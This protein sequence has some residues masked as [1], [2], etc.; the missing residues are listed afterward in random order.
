MIVAP[1]S[2]PRTSIPLSNFTSV[3]FTLAHSRN[4]LPPAMAFF[5]ARNP[6]AFTP[7]PVTIITTVVYLALLIP[8]L[9]IHVNVPSAPRTSPK[10][11][12]L[13]EAWQDLQTLTGGFHPYNS[14]RNDEVRG[15]LL[16]RIEAIKREV[17][18]TELALEDESRPDVFVFDDMISNL[19]SFDK[20]TGVYFEGTNILVYIRGWEDKKENWWE[21][22]GKSPAGKGGVLVNAHYDSV[23]TGYGATDDGVG[24]V[25][26]LQLLRY[27]L[28]PGHAPRRGLV[29]LFN[30]GEE[31]YLNGARAY[32]QHPMAKFAH[33][34][35]NLEGAGAGGRATLFR[36][37]DTEVTEAYS[38]TKYPFGTVI[39]A[40]G[41]ELVGS[42]TDY[43]VFEGMMGLRGLDVAFF[44][45]RARYHTDQDDSR[46]TSMDSVW[47]MLSAAVT[48]TQELVSDST[49]RFDGRIRDDG[50]VP[51]GTGTKAVWFDLFGSA[52]AVFQVH[53]LFALSVTLLIVAPLILLVTS[54]ALS[55]ADKMYLFRSTTY[56]EISDEKIALRGLRG[57]FR[58]PFMVVIPTA[59]VVGLAYLVTKI[60]PFIVHSSPYAVWSMMV[61]AWIFWL[62]YTWTWLFVLA[63][64]LLV[65]ATTFENEQGLGGGYF[66]L[67]YFAGTFLATW[68]SYLELFSLPTKSEYAGQFAQGSRRPS[69]YGS[70]LGATSGDEEEEQEVEEE[71]TESTSLLHGRQ[72]TTFA[73]YVNVPGDYTATHEINEGEE[74]DPHLYGNEQ[75]WSASMPSW[76]WL[77]Q[78]L[79]TVPIIVTILAPIGLLMTSA[80]GQTGQDGDPVLILYLFVAG[81]T[82]LLFMPMLPY[83]HRYTYHVPIFL[84]FILLGTLIYNLVAFPF[85]DSSRVKMYFSQQID[86]EKGNSTAYLTGVPPFVSDIVRGLPSSGG[87]TNCYQYLKRTQCSWPGPE[88]HVVESNTT[89]D[90]VT[91]SISEPESKSHPTRFE[92]SGQN[93]RSCRITMDN[94]PITT[95]SVVGSSAPDKRFLQP[96]ADGMHEIR[97]WSRTWGS[98]WTVDVNFSQDL[99]SEEE[100]SIKGRVSCIWSDNNRLGLIPALDEAK[101]YAPAWATM[102]KLADGL[103][104]G[105]KEFELVRSGSGSWKKNDV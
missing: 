39:S 14:H 69:S 76:S 41:F 64:V 12:N 45:P 15:W 10:G 5:K 80:L 93:T 8:I 26:C 23:S 22:P 53:T 66:T 60:N 54:I 100:S 31:D 62:V 105:Y 49:D 77:L 74:Q 38:K 7:W 70:R 34:F 11:L 82:A 96:S 50:N 40:N 92:I 25:T 98:N 36:T 102:T 97:L 88:P 33:T 42:Q 91:F 4:P 90:W 51:S 83:I 28:T 19:T 35:L 37:S 84:F 17:A 55:Q 95:F 18:S 57:F 67:F 21:T 87:Q 78:L 86:L 99:S 52:F 79:L 104:E 72:R 56:L 68:I 65:I 75:S 43:V 3:T 59:V 6:L 27:F 16:K 46:H 89:S 48:T 58:F 47:H 63:W 81:V 94:H 32:S 2:F 103:V 101:Q 73:N 9:V 20:R 29:I 30:N 13:T 71:P 61:A 1:T 44:E 24:V 85:S